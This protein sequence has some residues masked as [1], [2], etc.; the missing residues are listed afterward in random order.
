M[1]F[2]LLADIWSTKCVFFSDDAL[3][4]YIAED[5]F[6]NTFG[7]VSHNGLFIFPHFDK[8]VSQTSPCD[9]A[10]GWLETCTGTDAGRSRV[11]AESGLCWAACARLCW[12]TDTDER[13]ADSQL[14]I[15]GSHEMQTHCNDSW[16]HAVRL[17]WWVS[18]G[19]VAEFCRNDGGKV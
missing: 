15:A 1:Y 18:C 10:Y 17:E 7:S 13:E 11:Y 4:L 3:D 19:E 8:V 2:K 9:C 6:V 12:C 14:F 5:T 16:R